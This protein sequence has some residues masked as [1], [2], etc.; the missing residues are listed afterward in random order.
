MARK[1]IGW[2]KRAFIPSSPEDSPRTAINWLILFAPFIANGLWHSGWQ[3]QFWLWIPAAG[4]WTWN[5]TYAFVNRSYWR[6]FKELNENTQSTMHTM[7]IEIQQAYYRLHEHCP[8]CGSRLKPP[9]PTE[10]VQ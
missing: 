10:T 1:I 2:F 5:L 9:V 3:W 7:T 8:N 4:M 6:L